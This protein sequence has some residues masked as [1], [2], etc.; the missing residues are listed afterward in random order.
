MADQALVFLVEGHRTFWSRSLPRAVTKS[1]LVTW[2]WKRLPQF[3]TQVSSTMRVFI[4]APVLIL[5]V[6]FFFRALAASLGLTWE[7]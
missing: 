5:L 1:L 7:D 3:L 4:R 6:S 2:T